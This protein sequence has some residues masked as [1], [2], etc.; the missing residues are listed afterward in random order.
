[1]S[2]AP[3]SVSERAFQENYVRE[4]E[5]YKWKAVEELNGN[6]HEVTV[7]DLIAFWRSE[8][9]RINADQL[10]GVE[11]TDNEFQQ[12]MAKVNQINN[13]YE[14]AKI[15]SAENS[16]GKIDGIYR[17]KNPKVTRTQITLTIFRK[18]EVRGGDS[19]YRIA[20]EVRTKNGN[21]FDIVLLINGL[22]L[23]N[24]EQKRTDRSL[25]EAFYQFKRYYKDG[26]YSN[27]FMAFSQMMVISTEI[28]TR[29]FATPK[30]V[31]E[32]NPA[33]VF[34]WADEKNNPVND[35]KA[36]IKNFL[37]IPMAHQMVGDYLVIDE[38]ERVEDRRHLLLRPYQVYALRAIEKAAF[39]FDNEERIPHGGFVWH[40]T[41]SG[42]TITSFKTALFL[43]TRA[44]FDKVV[45][46]VDRKELDSN[47]SKKFKEYSKYEPVDVDDT[48][49]TH[50]LMKKLEQKNSS[51]IVATTHKLSA[52]VKHYIEQGDCSVAEKKII[53]IIDEAH[54]TT[55]GE[56]MQVIW[57]YFKKN[58]LFFGFTGTP[59][60]E[61]NNV[62]GR[63]KDSEL[64]NTTEKLFGPKLHEY[65]IDS[66]IADGN[67]LGFHVDYINTGEFISY[68]QLREELLEALILE[69]PEM[70]KKDIE[71]EVLK[72]E[73]H[74]L[75]AEA[76]S[77]GIL[78][79]QDETHIPRVV[80]E[81][82]TNWDAQSQNR[83]FNA[84][85]TAK[86]KHRVIAYYHEFKR[87]MQEKG[88]DLHIAMTFSVGSENADDTGEKMQAVPDEI[89]EEMLADYKGFTNL[90]L[91]IECLKGG[92]TNDYFEDLIERTKR[93]GS[94]VSEKNIDLVIVADQLLTGYDS[95]L[96]NTLYVDR[97]LELQNLIQAYSRTN[98]LYGKEK[99]FGT[100]INFQFPAI[101]KEAVEEALRLYGSGG[102]S[103]HVIVDT[104]NVAVSKFSNLLVTMVESLNDPAEWMRLVNSADEKNIFLKAFRAA[105]AQ[106]NVLQQYYEYAWDDE[107]F[108]MDEHTWLKYAGAYRNLTR[109][110]P[111]IDTPS[112]VRA[113]KGKTKLVGTQVIDAASL[114]KLIG[115]KVTTEGD[116]QYV[117]EETLR[118]IYEHIQEVSDMG[119]SVKAS[120]LKEFVDTRLI[121]GMIPASVSF[122]AAFDAWCKEGIKRAVNSMAIRLGV[123]E[124]LLYRSVLDY[125]SNEPEV[126]PYLEDLIDS[127]DYENATEKESNRLMHVIAMTNN[128]SK[129]IREIRELYL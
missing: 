123:S 94:G 26:E 105:A 45:F 75:E 110:D 101:T 126:V 115:S 42:K 31:Q 62:K 6:T 2:N 36:I 129:N 109:N 69:H 13:S 5:K 82:L 86:Y 48:P 116:V 30:S 24:I 107:A 122:D 39:G 112:V 22:P 90:E 51:I 87:Q 77:R 1:M 11:L 93:G 20:R 99:E 72:L 114:L 65:T 7:D 88:I 68:D 43:A 61:E 81:I 108:G 106:H 113:I 117:D 27:N 41:G 14:A 57:E 16:V 118:L 25:D 10:E 15:L 95:K 55:M 102:T 124:E 71:R 19:S 103:S 44:G 58:S 97:A 104:Y 54:R 67:V 40:T 78:I 3:K 70:L 64:I 120:L 4:L 80:E 66:A 46:L 38:A 79:Y 60:F 125:D 83:H 50:R 89:L 28:E 121:T 63:I 119:D 33:F 85:L 37:M 49:Y 18:P 91:D 111:P 92:R 12:V 73:K 52:L 76:S 8:L 21:R 59:L 98:R 74:E 84:I 127:L 23:I 35:Y 96:L 17:D 34:H 47:T 100:I 9:N 56:M 29:Y 32:F 53:F 128:L